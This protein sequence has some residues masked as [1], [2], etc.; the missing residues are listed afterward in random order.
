[1][2]TI[3]DHGTARWPC[4]RRWIRNVVAP[5]TT[6]LGAVVRAVRLRHVLLILALLIFTYVTVIH[7]WML[8]R[9]ST[10][11]ERQLVLP[12][13][14]LRPGEPVQYTQA[15]TIEAP[16]GAIW[17]WLMQVGQDK[18]GFY[19]CT[20]LEN[21]IGLDIHNA[22][23][24]HPEWQELSVGDSSRLAPRDYLW[25]IGEGAVTPVRMMEPDR[26]LVL[27]V[28]GAYVLEPLDAD[29]RSSAHPAGGRQRLSHARLRNGAAHPHRFRGHLRHPCDR[30]GPRPSARTGVRLR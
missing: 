13:D 7:P 29:G 18:G 21:L 16:P 4:R 10:P 2:S 3:R 30:V 17:P 1:M 12:G 22:D 25:G 19:T 26:A 20:W 14:G 6:S 28:W 5:L 8:E 23:S 15:V 27:D 24:V 11:T 9:G